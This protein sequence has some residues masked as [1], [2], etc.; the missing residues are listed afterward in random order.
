MLCSLVCLPLTNRIITLPN[1]KDHFR[2]GNQSH[3]ISFRTAP[4]EIPYESVA[5]WAPAPGIFAVTSD[6]PLSHR[7]DEKDLGSSPSL[8]YLDWAPLLTVCF[9]LTKSGIIIYIRFYFRGDQPHSFMV[10]YLAHE[11]I[12]GAQVPGL[13]AVDEQQAITHRRDHR[14]DPGPWSSLPYL[15]LTLCKLAWLPC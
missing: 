12:T 13:F 2:V 14:Q 6:R 5:W 3:L 8:P 4:H 10:S 9:P 1:N 7:R 11:R 15:D